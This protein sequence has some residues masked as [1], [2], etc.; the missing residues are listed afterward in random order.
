MMLSGVL[1]P[2]LI[3]LFFPLALA[4]FSNGYNMAV[5]TQDLTFSDFQ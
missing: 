2:Y 3:P 4:L 1:F 5:S